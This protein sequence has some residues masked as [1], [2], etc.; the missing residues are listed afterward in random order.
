MDDTLL[1]GAATPYTARKFKFELD[2]YRSCS[3]SEIN[4]NKSKIFGWNCSPLDMLEI[5][6]IMGMEGSTTWDTFSYLGIPIFR[7]GPKVAHWLPLLDKLKNKIHAWGANW[8]NKAGKVVLMNS[9]LTSLPIYQCSVL[10]SPKTITNKVNELIRRFLWEGG[11]NCEKKIHL[12][13]WDK[14]MKPKMEGGLQIRNV[15]IQNLSMGGKILWNLITGKRTWSKQILKKKYFKGERQRCLENPTKTQK[16]SPIFTLCKRAIPHF[17]PK[18]TWIPGNGAKIKKFEDSILGD[19]ALNELSDLENIKSWLLSQN[20]T[21]LWHISTWNNDAHDSWASWNFGNYPNELEDEASALWSHLQRKSPLSANSKDK[22]G[23]GSGSGVYSAAASYAAILETPWVP[24]NPAPWETIWNFPSI[25]KIDI[26]IWTLLHNS[27]MTGDNLKR[28]GWEGPSRCSLC[29]HAEE[30]IEHLFISCEFTKEV[31][32]IMIGPAA[33]NLPNSVMDVIS[34]WI[35]LSPFNLS[36]KS[37]LKHAWM[38]TPK[39]LC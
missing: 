28:K 19:Q 23:W 12:V 32:R 8:L 18:L 21:T 34:N 5:S 25:P 36:K 26:F 2:T 9:V 35:S 14:V 4:Y 10:L 29:N 39:F 30:T 37:L 24:P 13:S 3:G 15:A 22:R 1:L 16:G 38:W 7:A 31:W 6:R 20:Y 17:I 33:D 11:R 27:I